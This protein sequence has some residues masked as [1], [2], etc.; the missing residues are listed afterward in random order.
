[1]DLGILRTADASYSNHCQAIAA[2]AS[3]TA[4]AIRYAFRSRDCNLMWAAF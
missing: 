2:K 1:M 3:R 4:G